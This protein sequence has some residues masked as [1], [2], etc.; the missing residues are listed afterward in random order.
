ARHRHADELV[1]RKRADALP[2]VAGVELARRMS[3]PLSELLQVVD[4]VSQNLHAEVMLREVGAVK[5]NVGSRE[6][7]QDEMK[8]FLS[9]AGIADAEYHLVD[10][11]GLSR[12]TLVTT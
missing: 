5:R 11:S 3:P 4:K 8:T 6:A 12:L 2:S 7:G 1:D 10:G 9:Q